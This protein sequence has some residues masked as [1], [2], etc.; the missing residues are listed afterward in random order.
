MTLNPQPIIY[1]I[2]T[3]AWL[4]DL[5]GKYGRSVTLATVPEKE[6]EAVASLGVD[7]LWLMGVW[8]RSPKGMR[9][10]GSLRG[11]QEEYALVLPDVLPEDVVGSPY[12]VHRYEVDERLGGAAGLACARDTLSAKGIGLIL[13]FVPNHVAAD[14]PWVSEHPEYFIQGSGEDLVRA[15]YD[16]FVSDGCIIAC[17][18]DPFFPPWTDTAQLNSF[19]PEL[20]KAALDSL[21][22]IASLC[23]GVRCDMAMLSI[24]SVFEKTW[25]KKAGAPPELEFWDELIPAVRLRHP[26]FLFMAEAYWDLEW[27]LQQQGFDYCYDKRLYDRLVQGTAESVRLHLSAG[28]DFQRKLIRFIEN[29]DEPRAASVFP[30]SRHRASAVVMA[31]LPGAK[32]LHD[33]QCEGREIRLPVQLGRRPE[34][35][36]DPELAVFYRTLLRIARSSAFREGE[37][38][39]CEIAGWPDNSTMRN[40]LAWCRRSGEERFL[41]VVNVSDQESQG[42]VRLPWMDLDG[43]SWILRDALNGAEYERDGR[44][45]LDPGLFVNLDPWGFHVLGF[46]PFITP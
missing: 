6:W 24:N 13:D 9:I 19:H 10:A 41:V 3:W 12:S 33:G 40:L 5:A 32:L 31:T 23:D 44:E 38:R 20:R 42:L 4:H 27:E 7:L 46:F 1:E 37:W 15:P 16:F 36:V 43:R 21:L 18:R 25:G 11:L 29:H 39:L 45:M 30:G 34:E 35:R 22:K 28:V 14:H 2:N 8:E 17:G 26:R